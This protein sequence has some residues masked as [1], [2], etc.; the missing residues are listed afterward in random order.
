MNEAFQREFKFLFE[1]IVDLLKL[2]DMDAKPF[3]QILRLSIH[4]TELLIISALFDA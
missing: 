2:I 3:G 4:F 1:L